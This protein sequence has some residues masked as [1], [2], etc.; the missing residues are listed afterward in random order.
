MDKI[1][2]LCRRR[3]FVF[4][5]SEIYGGLGSA[6][7]YGH[8][9]VLAKNERQGALAPGDDPGARRHRRARLG[10]HPP[11]ARLGGVRPSRRLQRPAR[12]LPDVQAALP[13]RPPR[14]RRARGG[15]LR[16]AAEQAPGRDARL[17]PHRGAQ[18]QPHALDEDRP[19]R[20]D[21][22]DRVPP[23]RDGAGHLRQLQERAPDRAPQAAVRDRAGRQVVPQ[24]D[25]A[26]KLPL[27]HARVRADGDG[28]LRAAGRGRRV[29]PLLGR[30]AL[31]LVHALRHPRGEPARP[32]A[33]RRRA[34]AL[35][36]RH[37]RH[38]VP[39]PDRLVG[40]RGD[41]EPRRLRPHG[42]TPSTPASRSSTSTTSGERYVPHVIEPA[43]GADRALLAFLVDAY[44]EEVVGERERTSS[45]STRASRR[46][47]PP[48]CR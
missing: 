41:R 47:R 22:L 23:P 26:G 21:R 15:P 5:S 45:A 20:G 30:G 25:H 46:S 39:V 33:R 19:G 2:S 38:R 27:P 11:P 32:A 18:L 12:R 48:S 8:Y 36:E 17:R 35:L 40:A 3:G 31:P 7:D 44:D 14:R 10:D 29:V 24:R 4:P 1:V 28:V 16:Q 9:G 6:Y 42:S 34:L 13:R 43:A 37:E